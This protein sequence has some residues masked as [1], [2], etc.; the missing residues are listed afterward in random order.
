[1][2]DY[3]AWHLIRRAN[4]TSPS[5]RPSYI[6]VKALQGNYQYELEVDGTESGAEIV[7]M[8]VG[9]GF[10]AID[11]SRIRLIFKYKDIADD[12][13]NS[14][15]ADLGVETGDVLH[16]AERKQFE[17]KVRG[18]GPGSVRPSGDYKW[19]FASVVSSALASS[20]GPRKVEMERLVQERDRL[21][22]EIERT[23]NLEIRAVAVKK[24]QDAARTF[25]E[26]RSKNTSSGSSHAGSDLGPSASESG[27]SSVVSLWSAAKRQAKVPRA[28][29]VE[30]LR[31]VLESL[32]VGRIV[33]LQMTGSRTPE[34]VRFLG[35]NK[36][37]MIVAGLLGGAFEK[38][39]LFDPCMLQDI[40][41]DDAKL[42]DQLD[43]PTVP[44]VTTQGVECLDDFRG[45]WEHQG[46]IQLQWGEAVNE[47]HQTSDFRIFRVL[48]D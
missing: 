29:I 31:D 19:P 3:K 37:G 23:R 20:S 25:N 10:K 46:A 39:H 36:D 40:G 15:L 2:A 28:Q 8:I 41:I 24:R 12:D 4:S 30:P 7:A 11:P 48:G 6:T 26:L 42:A 38:T 22:A 35:L 32:P 45:A 27:R 21:N 16:I 33:Q 13:C 17:E 1:M 34:V 14:G 18:G 44:E 47:K 5:N 9:R 43:A